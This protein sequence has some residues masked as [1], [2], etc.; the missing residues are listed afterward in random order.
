[1]VIGILTRHRER[2]PERETI[3]M[4]GGRKAW[5]EMMVWQEA[6]ENEM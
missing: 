5:M 6:G 1:M 2:V 3:D 4:V